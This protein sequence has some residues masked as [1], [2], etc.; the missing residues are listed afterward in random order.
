MLYKEATPPAQQVCVGSDSYLRLFQKCSRACVL[1]AATDGMPF[2]TEDA[3]YELHTDTL[4]E[5]LWV[6]C[7]PLAHSCIVVCLY[8]ACEISSL[9][10]RAGCV[11]LI[12]Q[13]THV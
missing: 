13:L 5:L 10:H 1:P 9:V 12:L 8:A 4:S 7:A 2:F 3:M 11:T 6:R